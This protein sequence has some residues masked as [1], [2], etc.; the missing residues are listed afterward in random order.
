M[1]RTKEFDQ[2]Q[3]LA[4]AVVA[5]REHGLAGTSTDALLRAMGIS[6]QSMYET[7][8]D[9]KRLYLSALHHYNEANVTEIIREM[10]AAKIPLSLERGS[11]GRSFEEQDGACHG[12]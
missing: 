3:A 7:F 8:G 12:R 9:K 5:F 11:D 1:A 6:R 10:S 2:D 4:C